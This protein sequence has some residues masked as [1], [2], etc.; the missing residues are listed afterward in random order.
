MGPGAL[1]TYNGALVSIDVNPAKGEFRP[2]AEDF[3]ARG[4]PG[5]ALAMGHNVV[6]IVAGGTYRLGM[7]KSLT[8]T[9]SI[10]S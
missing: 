3:A 2:G 1:S 7:P 4:G 6:G 10:R 8:W 5:T 9:S